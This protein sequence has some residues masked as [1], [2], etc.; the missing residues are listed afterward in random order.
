MLI[1]TEYIFKHEL[2]PLA[3]YFSLDDIKKSI[4]KI[5]SSGVEMSNFGYKHCKIVKVRLQGRAHGRMIV[6]IQTEQDYYFPVVV[7]L[8]KDKVFGQNLSLTNKKAEAKILYNLA[9]IFEDLKLG[10]YQKYL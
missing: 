4:S 7:C 9:K 8:K 6:Y 10:R 3:K 2:R 5:A 1:I